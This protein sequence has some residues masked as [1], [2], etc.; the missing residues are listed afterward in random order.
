MSWRLL[1]H[2]CIV[3]S[4]QIRVYKKKEIS[5]EKGTE[6]YRFSPY[7]PSIAQ[8]FVDVCIE[9]PHMFNFKW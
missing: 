5:N 2:S 7:V 3:Y 6:V 4:T 8:V 1:I 9:N